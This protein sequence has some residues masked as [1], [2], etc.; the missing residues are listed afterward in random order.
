MPYYDFACPHGH[1]F[2]ENVKVADRELPIPCQGKVR[3]LCD[4]TDEGAV[5]ETVAM[6]PR[7]DGEQVAVEMDRAMRSE[8]NGDAEAAPLAP[9]PAV[10][11]WVRYVPCMLKARRVNDGISQTGKAPTLHYGFGANRDA[12]NEGRWDGKPIKRGLGRSNI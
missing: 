6:E 8:F 7:T 4:E 3:Q 12:A 5:K 2:E 10:E 9:P 1:T 11:V